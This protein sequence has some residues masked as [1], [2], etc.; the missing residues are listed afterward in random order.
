MGLG[1]AEHQGAPPLQQEPWRQSRGGGGGGA[2][3]GV[4]VLWTAFL[5]CFLF[6]ILI[7]NFF[8]TNRDTS[9]FNFYFLFHVIVLS[10]C[11]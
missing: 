8:F 7:F 10:F 6:L 2:D 1:A 5:A 3:H 4:T 9:L 11:F